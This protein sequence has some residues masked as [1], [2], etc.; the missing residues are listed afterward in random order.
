MAIL[1]THPPNGTNE[2]VDSLTIDAGRSS[3]PISN[4]VRILLGIT[5]RA[6][7]NDRPLRMVPGLSCTR[8]LVFN[9]FPDM[10]GG[11]PSI[12]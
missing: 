4:V 2:L 3:W 12:S 9:G 11:I 5:T 6:Y 10:H 7:E 1:L 8:A